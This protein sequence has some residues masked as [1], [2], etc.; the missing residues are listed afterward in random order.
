MDTESLAHTK[1]N[2]NY[3]IV[4]A[5]KYR[6]Q[7][8]YGKLKKDI[9]KILRDLC[10]RKGVEIIEAEL[11]NDH[12]H[13]LVKIPPKMSISSF[14]GYLKGKSTLMIFERHAN[15]KY[16]YGQRKFWCRG[17]YVDTVGKNKKVIEEYIRNQIYEDKMYDQMS[18]KEFVDPFTG[19]KIK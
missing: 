19:E 7:V 5:P 10:A 3:H 17:Y 13:M 6:R 16:K 15:L 8:I 12:V 1:W 9:G 18:M 11:C 4:F 14:M 2:C